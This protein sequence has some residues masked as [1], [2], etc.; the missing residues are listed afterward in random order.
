MNTRQGL[1]SPRA[2]IIIIVLALICSVHVGLSQDIAG[3][4]LT[5]EAV[6]ATDLQTMN[7]MTMKCQFVTKGNESVTWIQKK[8]TLTKVYSIVSTEGAWKNVS[9]VGSRTYF[10]SDNGKPCKMTVEKNANGTFIT[11]DFS[12]AGEYTARHRFKIESVK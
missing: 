7:P 1:A 2:K 3:G 4:T 6:E 9:S 12:K 8:G 10:L 11:M 5:W